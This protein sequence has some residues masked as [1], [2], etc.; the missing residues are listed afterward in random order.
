[1]FGIASLFYLEKD[2]FKKT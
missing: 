1:M 2:S